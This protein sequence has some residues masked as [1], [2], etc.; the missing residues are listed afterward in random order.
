[1]TPFTSQ[2]SRVNFRDN[3]IDALSQSILPLA[4]VW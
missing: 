4:V 1:M 2:L 3:P